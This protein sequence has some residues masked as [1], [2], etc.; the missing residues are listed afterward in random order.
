MIPANIS[1]SNPRVWNFQWVCAEK[2]RHRDY[3]HTCP[4]RNS[5]NASHTHDSAHKASWWWSSKAWR[6]PLEV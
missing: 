1:F 4:S 5:A 6:I 2:Y 3:V